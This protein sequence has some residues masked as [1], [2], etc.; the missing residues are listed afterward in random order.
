[1]DETIFEIEKWRGMWF[2]KSGSRYTGPFGRRD[3]AEEA[4]RNELISIAGHGAHAGR[5]GGKRMAIY[6]G[7][8][9]LRSA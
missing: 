6:P 5:E 1:M 2:Y 3:Q 8:S 7:E 4:V 9:S